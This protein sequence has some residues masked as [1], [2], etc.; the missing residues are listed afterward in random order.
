MKSDGK[1]NI[2]EDMKNNNENNYNSEG[3]L[4]HKESKRQYNSKFSSSN[5]NKNISSTESVENPKFNKTTKNFLH[6]LP[7]NKTSKSSRN[8]KNT[9]FKKIKSKTQLT[10]FQSYSDL[11]TFYSEDGNK[12][13]E[14]INKFNS[15]TI[16]KREI[17]NY[18]SSL[19]SKL[20]FY[21]SQ[22]NFFHYKELN[23]KI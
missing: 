4:F 23:L 10:F 12:L 5:I 8:L 15:I 20:D 2:K 3:D 17:L 9:S 1:K 14:L 7:F 22:L 19:Q 6:N 11:I 18:I 21:G 13:N 16:T